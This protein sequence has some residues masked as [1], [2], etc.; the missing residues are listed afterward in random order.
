MQK[1]V[2]SKSQLGKPERPNSAAFVPRAVAGANFCHFA[3]GLLLVASLVGCGR[4]EQAAAA[5]PAKVSAA[6]SVETFGVDEVVRAMTAAQAKCDAA[7]LDNLDACAE[8]PSGPDGVG[9]SARMA[10][11]TYDTFLAGC[12]PALSRSRCE[13]MFTFAYLS[14]AGKSESAKVAQ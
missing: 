4:S 13:D 10:R 14:N 6:A 3:L 7:G 2:C 5:Q 9:L 11:D 1:I 12:A 8:V